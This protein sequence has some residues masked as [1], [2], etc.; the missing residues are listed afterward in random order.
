MPPD[1]LISITI[2]GDGL[3]GENRDQPTTRE[4][5]VRAKN[6]AQALKHVLTDTITIEAASID[7]AMRIGAA[8]GTVEIAA[9]E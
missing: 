2:P 4:R 3:H 5:I 1:Y 6:Q 7:D 9:E 8:G